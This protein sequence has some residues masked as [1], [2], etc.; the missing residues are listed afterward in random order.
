[1]WAWLRRRRRWRRIEE[2]EVALKAEG[3]VFETWTYG[4]EPSDEFSAR[5]YLQPRY[6]TLSP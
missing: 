4:W 2:L 1:M 6:R 5:A 3:G